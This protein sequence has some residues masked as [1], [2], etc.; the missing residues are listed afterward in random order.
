MITPEMIEIIECSTLADLL[1][2][3]EIEK[4]P[5]IIDAIEAEITRIQ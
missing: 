3:L 1:D 5:E 2:A 4:D